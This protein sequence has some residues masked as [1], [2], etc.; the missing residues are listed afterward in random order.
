MTIEK[1]LPWIAMVIIIAQHALLWALVYMTR[2]AQKHA[3]EAWDYVVTLYDL[4]KE[5]H[6]E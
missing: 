1:M 5:P 3:N 6:N 4:E 2:T